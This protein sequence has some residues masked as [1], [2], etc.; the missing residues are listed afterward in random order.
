TLD[1]LARAGK[2]GRGIATY[3]NARA[4]QYQT[5]RR[6]QGK[7]VHPHGEPWLHLQSPYTF[8]AP[9]RGCLE[10]P[11]YHFIPFHPKQRDH[12]MRSDLLGLYF[13]TPR[14]KVSCGRFEIWIYDGLIANQFTLF[15]RSMLAFR[16]RTRLPCQRPVEPRELGGLVRNFAPAEGE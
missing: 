14:E 16:C 10:G 9:R 8:L 5:R 4:N 2:I 12:P 6:V 11:R 7:V 1:R 13:G 3:W 15:L